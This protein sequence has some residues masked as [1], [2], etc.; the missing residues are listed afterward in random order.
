MKHNAFSRPSLLALGSL[1][2]VTTALAEQVIFTEIQYNAQS[3]QPEFIEVKNITGTP[4]DLGTWAFTDGINYTFPDFNPSDTDA[5]IFQPFETILVS[6]VSETD[7]RTAY[8]SIP[9]GVRIFGPYTGALSNSGET[10]TLSDKNGV[11]MTTIEYN[12]GGKWPAAADGTGHTLSRINPNLS[13]RE[14][15]NWAASTA[16]N[17]TPGKDNN[18]LTTP[19]IVISEVHFNQDGNADWIEIHSPGDA[20]GDL[21]GVSFSTEK[22]LSDSS[23]LTGSISPGGYV[24]IPVN[25]TPDDNGD[26]DLYLF[27]DGSLQVLDAVRLDRDNDEESFQSFPVGDEFYGGP[28]HTQNAPNNPSA[29]QTNIVI[30]EIMYD[31]LLYTSDAADE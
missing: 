11:I 19:S 24:S 28:G 20:S 23:P 9:A 10:L 2:S 3:G 18:P 17:G 22:D 8:P 1:F 16:V 29:R 25:F 26:L 6:P 15:R 31:C 21:A 14:W 5:H 4:L 12:D 30:N 27:F 13:N 7:L